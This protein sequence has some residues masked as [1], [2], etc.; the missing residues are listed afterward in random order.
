MFSPL[1]KM[2]SKS[3]L[4]IGAGRDD[5]MTVHYFVSPESPAIRKEAST[6]PTILWK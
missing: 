3:P 5:T 4:R 1:E 6:Q 2:N